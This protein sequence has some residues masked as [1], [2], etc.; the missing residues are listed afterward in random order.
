MWFV[1]QPFA[2]QILIQVVP[3]PL[4]IIGTNSP[5]PAAVVSIIEEMHNHWTNKQNQK[6]LEVKQEQ[7]QQQ[8][9]AIQTA[10]AT[11]MIKSNM[12]W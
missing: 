5:P 6:A 7:Q 1:L 11:Q 4:E 9:A 8:Q 3:F 10:S 2:F 12:S